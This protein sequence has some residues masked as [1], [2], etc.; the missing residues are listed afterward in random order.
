MGEPPPHPDLDWARIH[1]LV[2]DPQYYGKIRVLLYN[3]RQGVDEDAAYSN[4]VHQT[5][6]EIEK[7]V[8]GHLAAGNFQTAPLSGRPMAE[9]DFQERQVSDADA[10]LA[11]ADLMGP[12]AARRVSQAA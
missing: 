4:S 8:Q 9:S 10:R 1:L 2:T 3:L 7:Q 6:A 5:P 12:Q 11:R